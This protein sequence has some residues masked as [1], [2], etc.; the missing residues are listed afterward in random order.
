MMEDIGNKIILKSKYKKKMNS[1]IKKNM[2]IENQNREKNNLTNKNSTAEEIKVNE[3][4]SNT[5]LK[6]ELNNNNNLEKINKKNILNYEKISLS[7][8]H[9]LF[10]IELFPKKGRVKNFLKL[11]NK[12]YS[13]MTVD[14]IYLLNENISDEDIIYEKK[15][16]IN[17]TKEYSLKE[18]T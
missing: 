11:R 12:I 4:M 8:Y 3:E 2:N 17:H 15:G 14:N 10:P 16:V 7:W 13:K 6:Q 1:L 5:K 18:K 9:F